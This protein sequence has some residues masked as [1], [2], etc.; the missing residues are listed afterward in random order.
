MAFEYEALKK[1]QAYD[2]TKA[3]YQREELELKYQERLQIELSE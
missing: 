1:T 3:R 2:M